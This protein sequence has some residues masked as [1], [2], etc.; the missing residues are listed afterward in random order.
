MS[1]VWRC[2]G[3]TEITVLNSAFTLHSGKTAQKRSREY[4]YIRLS[5]STVTGIKF[6]LKG[7]PSKLLQLLIPF[8]PV[9]IA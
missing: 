5:G 4:S 9:L 6:V 2:S 3:D 7:F 1:Q 8:M